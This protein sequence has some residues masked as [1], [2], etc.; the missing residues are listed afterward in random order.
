MPRTILVITPWK[1][2]WELG[3]AAGLADDLHF[4]RALGERGFEVHYAGPRDAAGPDLDLPGYVLHP[5]PALDTIERWPTP[6]RRLAWPAVFT[7][8]AIRAGRR[9]GREHPP[10]LVLGQTYLS[11]LAARRL[12]RYFGV[13][14]AVKLFGVTDLDRT[15]WPRWKYLRKNMEQVLAFKVPQDAWLILDDG[16][17]GAAAARRHGIAP[18]RIHL[19]PNGVDLAWGERPKD[20]GAAA[21]YGI[22]DGAAVVLY[23]ARLVDWKRPDVFLQSVPRILAHSR[24]PVHVLVAGEGPMRTGCEALASRLGIAASVRFLAAVPHDD[25]PDL[26]SVTDVFA[27]TNRRSNLGIPTCEAMTCGVPVVAFDTGETRRAVRNGETGRLVADGDVDAFAN[28]VV[29][30]LNDDDAR[31]RVGR[32]ARAFARETFT[33]WPERERM[34]ADLIE[35]LV[36][37]GRERR[38]GQ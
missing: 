24:R 21:R 26:L 33:D 25:V 37:G 18:E 14:S 32:H 13:P 22:P 28:A 3:H 8:R 27:T 1:R 23:L 30:L 31:R 12:A 19:L 16:T 29:A 35:A 36:R 20:P 7:S 9:V 6:L 15:D 2:R 11:A 34:E 5:F 38:N 10:S 4:V 17:G